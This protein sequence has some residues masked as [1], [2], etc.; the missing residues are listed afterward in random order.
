M[1]E[2]WKRYGVSFPGTLSEIRRQH[3]ALAVWEAMDVPSAWFSAVSREQA[4]RLLREAVE[5]DTIL[6]T[7]QQELSGFFRAHGV[8]LRTD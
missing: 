3:Q 5:H 1:A 7:K 2:T 8:T 4:G 6:R